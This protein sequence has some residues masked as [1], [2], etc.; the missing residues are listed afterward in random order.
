MLDFS[1]KPFYLTSKQSEWIKDTIASM[2]IE[3]KAGQLF[4]EVIWGEED[5]NADRIFQTYMPGGVMFRDLSAAA[6]HRLSE[7]VQGKSKIPMLIAANLERGGNGVVKEGT[8]FSTPMAAAATD[9]ETHAYH[10]GKVS[11]GEGAA[12]GVNWTFEPVVDLNYN[13]LSSITNTRTFG[14]DPDRV[15]RMAKAYMQGAREEGCVPCIKHFPGD[16]MDYRDQHLLASVNTCSIA[17]WESTYGKVYRELIEDG[18]ETLMAAHIKLPAYSKALNPS[19]KDEEILPASLSKELLTTL[20]R[21]KMGFQGLIVSDATNMVGFTA[22]MERKRAVPESIAAGVDMFLFTVNQEEDY[23]YMLEGIRN[24][25]ITPERLDEAVSRILALKASLHL[26]EKQAEGSLV[27]PF[28][29]A[30]EVIGNHQFETW[31]RECADHA[32]TLVKNKENLLPIDSKKTKRILF[33]VIKLSQKQENDYDSNSELFRK[34][35]EERGFELIDFQPD[36]LPGGLINEQKISEIRNK[37]DMILY[38]VT[39]DVKSNQ[40]DIRIGWTSFLGGDTPKFI[41][42]IPTVFISMSNPYHLADVPMVSTYI[43]TYSP[44]RFSVEELVKKITGESEFV[45]INPVDPFCGLWDT[46]L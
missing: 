38:F 20:L 15:I 9:D 35:M 31:A 24:G 30:M 40:K 7:R 16:G 19:L 46:R 17:Q 18:A 14:S 39:C 2:T 12:V 29:K 43:N 4:C 41:K 26:P 28:N 10:L 36:S 42:E 22:S 33:R 23:Q 45:G 6:V 8:Y 11:C 1:G 27:P 13:Y 37:Y 34:L 44:C 3:E 21:E 32:I 25:I 5:Q